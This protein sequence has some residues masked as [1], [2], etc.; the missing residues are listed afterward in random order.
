LAPTTRRELRYSIVGDDKDFRRTLTGINRSLGESEARFKRYRNVVAGS[1]V[2]R[3][4]VGF[5]RAIVGTAAQFDSSMRT[6]RAVTGATN[7]EMEQFRKLALDMGVKSGLGARKAAEAI[8]ELAK[9]GLSA[10][11]IIG[12]GLAGAMGLATAGGLDL[13]DAASTTANALN[14][15]HLEGTQATHVADALATAANATTADVADFSLALAQGGG[16]AKAAGLSFDETVAALEALAQAGVKGSDAGTSLKNALTQIARPSAAA[17]AEMKKL[18]I[19]FFNAQGSIK[20]LPE[21]AALLRDRFSH[22][23]KEQRLHAAATIASTDGMRG[24]LALA[25]AGPAKMKKFEDGLAKQ[26]TAADIARQKNA[27]FEGS[28]RRLQA[29]AESLGISIGTA[30]LPALTKA[31]DAAAKFVDQMRTGTGA[32]GRFRQTL[33]DIANKIKPIVGFFKDHPKLIAVAIGAW[34]LYKTASLAALAAISIKRFRAAFFKSVPVAGQAGAAAGASF[35]STYTATSSTAVTGAAAKGG[36]LSGVMSKA[37]RGLGAVM[38]IAMVAQLASSLRGQSGIQGLLDNIM[39]LSP[40]GSSGGMGPL[41][42]VYKNGKLVQVRGTSGY[43]LARQGKVIGFPHQGTHTLGNWQSDN[44]IDIATPIGTAVLAD[45]NA[46]VVK[47]AGQWDGGKSRFDGFQVTLRGKNGGTFYTH[48]EKATVRVGQ[49]VHIGQVIGLS[50]AANGVA[51][52]HIGVER[53]NPVD[54]FGGTENRGGIQGTGIIQHRRP[55][56][57]QGGVGPNGTACRRSGP[58]AREASRPVI[59]RAA[60]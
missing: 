42:Q 56:G 38:G 51:H 33:E 14:L 22:L 60:F 12:G 4:V 3:E 23:T 39:P 21:L 46:T 34:A 45:E 25:S 20:P 53:G 10:Q 35:A 47:I 29:S 15:F 36:K 41:N 6:I 1:F 55:G 16:A 13:A 54:R 58:R 44:A 11:K 24:L 57:G 50:G 32:G 5:G 49:K 30:V 43:P 28:M 59:G 9:G 27:G 52:L 8:T 7:K 31:A 40:H 48:L 19:E 17:K 2:T 18:N 26:G 37:G